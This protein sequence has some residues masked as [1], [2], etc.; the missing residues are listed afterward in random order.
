MVVGTIRLPEVSA[1]TEEDMNIR[2]EHLEVSGTE[3]AELVATELVRSSIWFACEPMPD[4]VFEFTVKEE[5]VWHLK[6]AIPQLP[7]RP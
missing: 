6:R 2:T 5:A 3:A 7:V 1:R 4:D